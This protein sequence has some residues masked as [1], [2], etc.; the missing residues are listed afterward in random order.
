MIKITVDITLI[1]R[2]Q[3]FRELAEDAAVLNLK[4]YTSENGSK[5]VYEDATPTDY[6]YAKIT[7]QDV[8]G[9]VSQGGI[10]EGYQC[11]V[12]MTKAYA[13]ATDVP[14]GF[15]VSTKTLADDSVVQKTWS[16]YTPKNTIDITGVDYILKESSDG[17][18]YWDGTFI[19]ACF[20]NS[21]ISILTPQQYKALFPSDLP[22]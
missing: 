13:D 8:A 5:M 21:D 15:P 7:P 6:F 9:I 4:R 12:K 11:F 2:G 14:V 18:K 22:A 10:V 1:E 20:A 17:S 3:V 19:A 16:E